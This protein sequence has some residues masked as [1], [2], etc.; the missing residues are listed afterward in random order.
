MTTNLIYQIFKCIIPFVIIIVQY[1]QTELGSFFRALEVGRRFL[2]METPQHGLKSG[3]QSGGLCLCPPKRISAFQADISFS[4]RSGGLKVE[5]IEVIL[6]I[7]QRSTTGQRSSTIILV[8][9]T[10]F[11]CLDQVCFFSVLFAC[12]PSYKNINL[13]CF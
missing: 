2:E 11:R 1:F 9:V 12:L 4:G 13:I 8:G 7:S 6:Y 10:V 3:V 5:T